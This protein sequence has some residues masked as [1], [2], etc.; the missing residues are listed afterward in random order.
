MLFADNL[1]TMSSVKKKKPSFTFFC[2]YKKIEE[3]Y[4]QQ[5][6]ANLFAHIAGKPSISISISRYLEI[7][8]RERMSPQPFFPRFSQRKN[9]IQDISSLLTICC[10]EKKQLFSFFV[11]EI[12]D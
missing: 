10:C 7:E 12:R 8:K 2:G 4:Q 11:L 6:I 5:T 3:K 1:L 9:G